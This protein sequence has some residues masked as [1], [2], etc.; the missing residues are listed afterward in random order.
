MADGSQS[1]IVDFAGQVV[2]L[3]LQ[4]P[5]N[6]SVGWAHQLVSRHKLVKRKRCI[7][8]VDK[9]LGKTWTVLSIFEH[10][11]I[12]KNIPGFTVLI[13]CPEKGMGSY[14]RDLKKFPDPEGKIQ[15][16]YGQ[17]HQR[18]RQWKNSHARYFICTYASF[19]SDLGQRVTNK[20]TKVLSQVIAPQWALK[21]Q[22]DGVVFDEFHRQFRNRTS[23]AFKVFAKFFKNTEYVYPMSG[24]AVSKGPQDLWPA[25]HIVDP[26]FWSTY[27]GYVYTWCEVDDWGFG[28]TIT[29]PKTDRVQAWRNAVGPYV[30]HI[31]AEQVQG[32]PE[33][34]RDFLDVQLPAWQMKLHNDLRDNLYLETPDGEFIFASNVLTKINK[35]RNILIC[36]KTLSPE[37]D[38]GQAIIDVADNALD[39]GVNRYCIFTPFKAPIPIFA[40]WLRSRGAR[41]WILQGGIGL[42][43]QTRRL[44]AWRSSLVS[45]T[46]ENPSIIIT[47]V[48]YAESWEI[49][50]CRYGYF[51]GEEW[52]PE[53]NKQGEDRLKR[54]ISVGVTYIQYCRFLYTYQEE[55]IT[56][57]LEKSANVRIMF[58]KW[59]NFKALLT[60]KVLETDL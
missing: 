21:G 10:E 48:K 26:K 52:D 53:E 12:H 28:K 37:Y 22:I 13:L 23:T 16:V 17:G 50:E 60:Q 57:L 6:T 35:L 46:P 36:P 39:G 32:M 11:E 20:K 33:K 1:P 14:I 2:S 25:L 29:G 8:S 24:S 49:P 59:V 40:D 47:T 4:Q 34:V 19:L 43:E 27:W 3:G 18:E 31:K 51:I 7:L 9:G 45:A 58:G 41:V 56:L 15:L 5:F 30:M 42:D 54:M 38:V 44:E 55:I